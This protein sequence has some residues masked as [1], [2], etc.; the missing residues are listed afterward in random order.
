MNPASIEGPV[1]F[2]AFPHTQV[3]P[4]KGPQAIRLAEPR[5][6]HFRITM[7]SLRLAAPWGPS[8]WRNHGVPQ[9]GRTMGALSLAE[10]WGP[11]VWRHHGGPQFGGTMGALSLAAPWGPSVWRHHGGPQFGG[12]RGALS[13]AAPWGV[14]VFCH[15]NSINSLGI[16]WKFDACRVR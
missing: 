10:P 2:P 16:P 15:D 3:F 5:G 6:F 4:P 1:N 13:L 8:V 11:S 14:S 7:G 12:T 9:F